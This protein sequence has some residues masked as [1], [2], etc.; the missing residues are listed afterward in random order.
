MSEHDPID[1]SPLA[2]GGARWDAIVAGTAAGV[3]AVLEARAGTKSDPIV[4]LASWRRRVLATAAAILAILIP[5]EFAMEARESRR[6][7]VH[8]LALR[9]A[10][11][12]A[13]SEAP[14]GSEILRALAGPTP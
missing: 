8:Q 7:P 10:V 2:P 6:E 14:T 12:A 1:L 3:H 11:W 9:S 5:V 13:S 4:L